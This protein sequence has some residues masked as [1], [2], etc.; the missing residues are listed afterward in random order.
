MGRCG[1]NPSGG[2]QPKE[3][4]KPDHHSQQKQRKRSHNIIPKHV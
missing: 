4:L 3:S 1:L 2:R